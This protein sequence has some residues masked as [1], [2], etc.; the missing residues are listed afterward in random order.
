[1]AG[2]KGKGDADLGHHDCR[3]NRPRAAWAAPF[4][5]SRRRG[6]FRATPHR[7]RAHRDGRPKR[8]ALA[9]WQ[10]RCYLAEVHGPAAR[11]AFTA[12]RRRRR[13]L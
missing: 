2:Q 5:P 3:G 1:M 11:G 13:L 6:L 10:A 8:P 4:I 7:S 9:R 12:I